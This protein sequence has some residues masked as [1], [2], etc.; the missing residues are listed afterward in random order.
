M[1]KIYEYVVN[2]IGQVP[3]EL[4]FIY[5]IAT[6]IVI[7]FIMWAITMPFKIIYDLGK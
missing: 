6:L 7:F 3:S 1:I 4:E 2:V 5:A